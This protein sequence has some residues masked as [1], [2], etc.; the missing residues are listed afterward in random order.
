MLLMRSE[1][2]SDEKNFRFELILVSQQ[3]RLRFDI[4][5]SLFFSFRREEY[6]ANSFEI[7][8]KRKHKIGNI[9]K[10]I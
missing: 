10:V 2:K 7:K 6:R 8:S 1:I 5:L 3:S 4:L 9:I